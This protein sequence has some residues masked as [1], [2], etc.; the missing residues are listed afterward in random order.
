MIFSFI[1]ANHTKSQQ[2]QCIQLWTCPCSQLPTPLIQPTSHDANQ[3]KSKWCQYIQLSLLPMQPILNGANYTKSNGANLTTLLVPIHPTLNGPNSTNFQQCNQ[4][5]AISDY[6]TYNPKFWIY[7][8]IS[9]Y[10]STLLIY[11]YSQY[12]ASKFL[13]NNYNQASQWCF[14]SYSPQIPKLL[15]PLHLNSANIPKYTL[16]M[17]PTLKSAFTKIS[18]VLMQLHLDGADSTGANHTKS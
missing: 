12:I 16:P 6:A 8:N 18:L 7:Q 9:K 14:I 2:C 17:Q 15:M 11:S 1:S 13:L 10:S 5:Q 3:T 4:H